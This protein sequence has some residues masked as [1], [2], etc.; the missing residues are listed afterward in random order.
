M[1]NMRKLDNSGVFGE[2]NRTDHLLIQNWRPNHLDLI[3]HVWRPA[4]VGNSAP[5]ARPFPSPSAHVT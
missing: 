1:N 2:K 3:N 4:S 5:R